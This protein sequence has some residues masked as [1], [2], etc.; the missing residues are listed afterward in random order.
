MNLTHVHLLLNHIPVIG[1]GFALL[2]LVASLLKKSDDLK[3]ASL[4][5]FILSALVALPTYFTGEP[6][7]ETVERL[8]GVSHAIIESHEEAALFALLAIEV[9]GVLALAA[10]FLY[11]RSEN[12]AR[13]LVLASLVVALVA[14]GLMG[15]TANLGGQIR[16]TEIRS[17][18][19]GDAQGS[20]GHEDD[21]SKEGRQEEREDRRE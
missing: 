1:V 8:P 5:L 12:L 20:Q 17:Q 19:A 7:E 16:H 4:W 10:L 14:G 18:T 9:L 11:R 15:W 21:R 6:A 2:L 13:L 3:R